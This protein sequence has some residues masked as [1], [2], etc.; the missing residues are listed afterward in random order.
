MRRVENLLPKDIFD[1]KGIEELNTLSDKEIEPILP[2]LLEWIKDLNWP[3]AEYMPEL[4]SKHQEI[5]IPCII[6]V[7]QPEQLECD[8]KNNIIWVLL[9]RLEK[10]Y[11]T[12]VKACLERIVHEPTQAEICEETDRAAKEFLD[13]FLSESRQDEKS[14]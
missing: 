13:K 11:L 6:K 5:L 1:I 8:W 4:F 9:P 10:K 3:V 7:L 14:I 12:M 2:A